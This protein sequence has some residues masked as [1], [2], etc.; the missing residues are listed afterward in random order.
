MPDQDKIE[1]V[2]PS[3]AS[4]DLPA[5]KPAKIPAEIDEAP[6]EIGGPRGPEP[7]RYGD[8]ERN[9]RCVDF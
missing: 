7:T 2:D 4:A 8:W 9:G 5:E 6:R 3:N 1:T